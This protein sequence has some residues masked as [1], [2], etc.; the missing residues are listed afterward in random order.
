[1]ESLAHARRA[2]Q[3]A[4]LNQSSL[5]VLL[6]DISVPGPESEASRAHDLGLNTAN[7]GGD[8]NQVRCLL[9]QKVI[10]CQS[11]CKNL[12]PAYASFVHSMRSPLNVPFDVSNNAGFRLFGVSQT[13]ITE[14]F[15]INTPPPFTRPC[16]IIE[17]HG[18]SP[19]HGS[20]YAI[21][22]LLPTCL[23]VAPTL[24]PDSSVRF[25]RP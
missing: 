20:S 25:A 6:L 15:F 21:E 16:S 8:S 14:P 1:M 12:R 23:Q 24:L 19:G 9:I 4:C 13:T 5:Y 7:V 18:V 17:A 11:K 2:H 3:L 22:T 10:A